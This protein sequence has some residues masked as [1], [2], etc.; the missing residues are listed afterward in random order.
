MY[1]RLRRL[2]RKLLDGYARSKRL[3]E[4]KASADHVTREILAD[5]LRKLGLVA[6]DTVFL[7]SS[8]KSLGYVEGGPAAVLNAFVDVLGPAGTLLLPAYHMPGGSIYGACNTPG[9][10]FDVRKHGTEM[11]ALP[12]AF[13]EFPGV[14]RSVH[15]THSCAALGRHARYLTEAHHLAPSVFG[16]GSPWERC[17]A[18]NGKVLGLGISMGPVTF[19]HLLEDAVGD[20]F[21][22]PVRLAQQFTIGCIDQ[23]GQQF[24][25]PVRPLDPALQSRRIDH[26]SRADLREYFFREFAEA[27]LLRSGPVA[28]ATAWYID[29]Q[30]FLDGLRHL[31]ESGVTIY[32]SPETLVAAAGA[33]RGLRPQ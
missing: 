15:P 24:S 17:L 2:A 12:K 3:R 11:G 21:P 28:G 29:S 9:Y 4:H 32:S 23:Y 27:R 1:R 7:H 20:A 14:Q 8:L 31:M 25:V 26:P 13:L 18:L 5:D 19:Y 30:A 10:V 16:Q 6:G 33:L 22:L